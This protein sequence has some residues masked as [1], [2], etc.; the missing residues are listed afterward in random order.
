MVQT[1]CLLQNKLFDKYSAAAVKTL[2]NT[3]CQFS[4]TY[5]DF[6]QNQNSL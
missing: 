5:T 1:F 3:E 4:T 2:K 6:C